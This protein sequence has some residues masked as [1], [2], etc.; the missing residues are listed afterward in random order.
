M[1][2]P[3]WSSPFARLCFHKTSSL[4]RTC[5]PLSNAHRLLLA[6]QFA[7]LVPFHPLRF[8]TLSTFGYT[9]FFTYSFGLA[10]SGSPVP[11]FSL[12]K[13]LAFSIPYT[14]QPIP[15]YNRCTLSQ[16]VTERCFRCKL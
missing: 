4:L 12:Y 14:M 11:L 6:S 16:R 2:L 3:D 8:R 15:V 10:S 5:P 9:T 7:L 1:T 13:C